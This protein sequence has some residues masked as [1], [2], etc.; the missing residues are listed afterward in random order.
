MNY[1]NYKKKTPELYRK[2]KFYCKFQSEIP[3]LCWI[4]VP[5]IATKANLTLPQK[6][7]A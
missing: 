1:M 2:L 3:M 7:S 6:K 5:R 4:S